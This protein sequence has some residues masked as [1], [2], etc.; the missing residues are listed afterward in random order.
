MRRVEC[1]VR[2]AG[3]PQH[4]YQVVAGFAML[5][6]RGEVDVRFDLLPAEEAPFSSPNVI[7]ATVAGRPVA[8]DMLDG[9]HN[10][11]RD[12]LE[13]LLSSVDVCFKRSFSPAENDSLAH[14]D[15][16]RAFGL[17]YPVT[18][19]A[20]VFRRM[21]AA[22][23]PRRRLVRAF[24]AA[25]GR[26][27]HPHV[28]AFEGG[29][30][31]RDDPVVVFMTR[32]YDPAG[33]PGEDPGVLLRENAGP[34][35][36]EINE[37]RAGCVR[38]LREAFGRSFVGGLAPTAFAAARYPDCLLDRA[39]V[40]R[41]R[42]LRTLKAADVG[43]ATMG[44]HRSNQW[45]LAE[46][47]AASKAVVSERLRYEVPGFTPPENYL[48]FDTPGECVERVADLLDDPDRR[49]AMMR[50]NQEHYEGYVRP[51]RAVRRTIVTTLDGVT[52]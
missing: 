38:R 12:E 16:I 31:V 14:G 25:A 9:Y 11:P 29:P 8:Y 40:S 19:R 26:S 4:V 18:C 39:E 6:A 21:R 45:K 41:S 3:N 22:D 30:V 33:E 47:L 43:V 15:R 5:G 13:G 49:L 27:P 24:K 44:L 48:S 35:R 28:K 32:V 23:P 20:A 37:M 52:A 50:A 42:F 17:S 36:Q 10:I 1:S 46:Y 51:D 34:E 2:V 7:T